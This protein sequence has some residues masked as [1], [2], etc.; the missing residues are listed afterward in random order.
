MSKHKREAAFIAPREIDPK[1]RR[2]WPV[3]S[4][5]E[6]VVALHAMQVEVGRAAGHL[7]GVIEH[8]GIEVTTRHDP[9]LRLQQQ[10]VAIAETRRIEAP[11][12][13]AAAERR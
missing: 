11:Q 9:P 3:E 10:A 7:A 1:R 4:Q 8:R 13:G 6:A 2:E 12:V 5:P